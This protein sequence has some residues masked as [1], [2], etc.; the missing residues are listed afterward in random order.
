MVDFVKIFFGEAQGNNAK[1]SC[2]ATILTIV[3]KKKHRNHSIRFL[4]NVCFLCRGSIKRVKLF[5]NKTLWDLQ[6]TQVLHPK[7]SDLT[8]AAVSS[9]SNVLSASFCTRMMQSCCN[10]SAMSM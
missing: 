10:I 4:K 6:K 3:T 2:V 5:I 8:I 1:S 9:K 7:E